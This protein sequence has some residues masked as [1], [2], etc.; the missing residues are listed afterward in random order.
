MQKNTAVCS[1]I[2]SQKQ[3]ITLKMAQIW[4]SSVELQKARR[5][6]STNIYWKGA[7]TENLLRRQAGP[8]GKL[9]KEA[10]TPLLPSQVYCLVVKSHTR[11]KHKRRLRKAHLLHYPSLPLSLLTWPAERALNW[12][13]CLL[14]VFSLMVSLEV[15]PREPEKYGAIRYVPPWQHIC[16]YEKLHQSILKTFLMKLMALTKSK[17]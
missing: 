13:M 8:E 5:Q 15:F 14:P 4:W 9:A 12:R 16:Q 17:R 7:R 6:D 10:Y 11:Q 3:Y 2:S 1:R